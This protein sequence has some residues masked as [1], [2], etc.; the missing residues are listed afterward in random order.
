MIVAMIKRLW[1]FLV[2]FLLVLTC[3]AQ[4][5]GRKVEGLI[6]VGYEY[7][8]IHR[9]LSDYPTGDFVYDYYYSTQQPGYYRRLNLRVGYQVNCFIFKM[10]IEH[11]KSVTEAASITYLSDTDYYINKF[12][13]I[14]MEFSYK[15]GKSNFFLTP[16]LGVLLKVGS[17][18]IWD[19]RDSDDGAA[20]KGLPPNIAVTSGI[21]INYQMGRV[22][23]YFYPRFDYTLIDQPDS[24]Y[25]QDYSP[26]KYHPYTIGG[27]LG[28]SL[29]L[30]NKDKN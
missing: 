13:N 27:Q 11:E 12:V 25:S 3:F 17:L 14:P 8:F 20:G 18:S 16:S 21:G 2:G 6:S 28:F 15:I 1:L 10:G 5:G 22:I 30:F 29:R 4:E 26:T 19:T 9:A 23:F 24:S 7:G